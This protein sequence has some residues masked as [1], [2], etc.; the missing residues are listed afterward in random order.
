LLL[1]YHHKKVDLSIQMFQFNYFH[2][3]FLRGHSIT[4][5]YFCLSYKV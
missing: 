2:H 3:F 5:F 1:S 4:M